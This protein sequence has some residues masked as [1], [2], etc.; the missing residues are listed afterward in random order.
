MIESYLALPPLL[1][2]IGLLVALGIYVVVNRYPEGSDEVKKIGDQI[3]LG[4]MTF[5]IT[6]Y[7]YFTIF[8]INISIFHWLFFRR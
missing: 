2:F 6:E 5:M 3:H 1:G 8:A 4:A 7:L